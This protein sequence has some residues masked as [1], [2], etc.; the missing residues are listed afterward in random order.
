MGSTMVP[1]GMELVSSHRLSMQTTLVSG[2]VWLQ[3][4]MQV[5]T[6]GCPSLGEGVVVC[7]RRWVP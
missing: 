5:L 2:T 7:G 4:S 1:L 6:G 3:F